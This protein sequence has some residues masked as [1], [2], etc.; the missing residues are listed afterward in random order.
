MSLFVDSSAFYAA[1]DDRDVDHARAVAVFSRGDALVTSDHVLV[2][3]WQLMRRR[4]SRFAADEFWS[5]I[6]GGLATIETVLPADLEA[7]WRIGHDFPDPD[8]SIVDRTSF[9]LMERLHLD[10]VASFDDHFAV[11][12]FGP[13][14]DRAFEIRR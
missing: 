11:Y 1:S 3:T 14:R 5:K 12:R 9:A 4:G 8:F 10:S 13:R 2:D 7:A 6:R